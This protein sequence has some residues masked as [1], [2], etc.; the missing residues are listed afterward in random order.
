MGMHVEVRGSALG[1]G[2]RAPCGLSLGSGSLLRVG[3]L[4]IIPGRSPCFHLFG[5]GITG[6]PATTPCFLP[7]YHGL[8]S[9]PP[10]LL[11][12]P[13]PQ[14]LQVSLEASTFA[15]VD[16]RCT[17]ETPS[18][19]HKVWTQDKEKI[20]TRAPLYPGVPLLF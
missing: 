17:D 12:E 15:V 5:D 10:A 18:V 20:W 19:L 6:A 1:D 8:N 14:L 16:E 13:S 4:A 9:G 11:T 2:P 3:W 7:G